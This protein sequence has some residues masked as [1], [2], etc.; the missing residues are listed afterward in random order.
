MYESSPEPT[1]NV[2]L[3]GSGHKMAPLPFMSKILL[4]PSNSRVL[5]RYT[6]TKLGTSAF[7]Q[8]RPLKIDGDQNSTR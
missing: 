7:H 6:R 4:S 1:I 5:L 3:P 8:P 2:R